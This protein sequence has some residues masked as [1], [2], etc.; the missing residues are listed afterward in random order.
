MCCGFCSVVQRMTGKTVPSLRRNSCIRWSLICYKRHSALAECLLCSLPDDLLEYGVG[1]PCAWQFSLP[2]NFTVSVHPDRY[3]RYGPSLG[4][5]SL[6]RE[7]FSH[8]SCR[9]FR[10]SPCLRPGLAPYSPR[11]LRK[12]PECGL[13]SGLQNHSWA[14]ASAGCLPK[15]REFTGYALAPDLCSPDARHRAFLSISR[16]NAPHHFPSCG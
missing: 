6:S 2:D 16:E 8:R 9:V 3:P 15:L 11:I 10:N 4:R 5:I 14:A 7:G 1:R 13:P 12:G